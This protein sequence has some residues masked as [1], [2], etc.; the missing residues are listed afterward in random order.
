MFEEK[1][2][3]YKELNERA[4]QLAH[5]LRSK[6]IREETLVPICIERS[7]EMIVGIFAILKAGAAYV[8]IDPKYPEERIRYMLEDINAKIVVSSKESRSKLPTS[9]GVEVVELDTDWRT[10]STQSIENLQ[11]DIQP[12]HLAYVIYTSKQRG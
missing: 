3:T 2:L 12:H 4:N 8:P 1:Q 9:E 6:G 10:I 7:L 11:T 5:Y